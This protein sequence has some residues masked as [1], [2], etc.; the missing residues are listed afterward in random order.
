MHAAPLRSLT[1]PRPDFVSPAQFELI[2]SVLDDEASLGRCITT[3]AYA[4][5]SVFVSILI[6]A[7]VWAIFG[8]MPFLSFLCFVPVWIWWFSSAATVRIKAREVARARFEQLNATDFRDC[9][10]AVVEQ[11]WPS[12]WRIE[13]SQDVSGY[14]IP[15]TILEPFGQ[16]R[17]ALSL[18]SFQLQ[19][20]VPAEERAELVKIVRDLNAVPSAPRAWCPSLHTILVAWTACEVVNLVFAAFSDGVDSVVLPSVRAVTGSLVSS[21]LMLAVGVPSF[22]SMVGEMQRIVQEANGKADLSFVIE[23]RQ[24]VVRLLFRLRVVYPPALLWPKPML[25]YVLIVRRRVVQ[26]QESSQQTA[27]TGAL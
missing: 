27:Q 16:T 6:V 2:R 23:L 24:P 11:G 15:L 20:L 12:E 8:V 17:F 3:A 7:L 22:D 4:A 9:G 13:R 10:F 1:T 18:S 26:E 19:L 5:L 14:A 25:Q 21:V